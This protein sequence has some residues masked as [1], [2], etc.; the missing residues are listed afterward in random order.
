MS[1]FIDSPPSSPAPAQP[2]MVIIGTG[3]AGFLTASAIS[4]KLIEKNASMP[5]TLI[6]D[7]PYLPY[8]RTALS[9][10]FLMGGVDPGRLNLQNSNWYIT[11]NVVLRLGDKI[12]E[13]NR[14]EQKLRFSMGGEIFYS[15]LILALGANAKHY[16]PN[17][18]RNPRKKTD[19]RRIITLENLDDA[20][21]LRSY[22][23]IGMR[24]V[25]IGGGFLGLELAS[26][27]ARMGCL[28]TVIEARPTMLACV[29]MPEITERLIEIHRLRSVEFYNND[30]CTGVNERPDLIEIA[31]A[32]HGTLMADMVVV[33][34]GIEPN[35][36]LAAK[37]GLKVNKDLGILVNQNGQTNDPLIFAVG[38]CSAMTDS[39]D[40]HHSG[41]KITSLPRHLG[42]IHEQINHLVATIFQESP[43]AANLP[44]VTSEQYGIELSILGQAFSSEPVIWRGHPLREPSTAF[45]TEDGRVI[46]AV[47][48]NTA[49]EIPHIT[50][51]INSKKRISAE[52]LSDLRVKLSDI[53]F[54]AKKG[55]NMQ[56]RMV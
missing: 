41:E 54:K 47:G 46:G 30:F 48:F 35:T 12:V 53:A 51:L 37:S 26:I 9:K 22:F 56:N 17:T 19:R 13:I 45:L 28:V 21:Y 44:L 3:V 52:S 2:G 42:A 8:D 24:L 15:S 50:A 31:T 16:L 1:V 5:I 20:L 43:P 29:M 39:A 14:T 25:I 55:G 36:E 23:Q 18:E 10:D 11:A 7:E 6:G 33:A 4:A 38:R 27:A 34:T 40:G 49:Q 32:N